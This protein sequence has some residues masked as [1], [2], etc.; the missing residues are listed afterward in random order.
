MHTHTHGSCSNVMEVRTLSWT[1]DKLIRR[2]SVHPSRSP[3]P[4]VMAM[5]I[6][7]DSLLARPKLDYD[8]GYDATVKGA[9]VVVLLHHM[10]KLSIYSN[11]PSFPVVKIN[12]MIPRILLGKLLQ[13]YIIC[14]FADPFYL[15]ILSSH[16]KY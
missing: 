14:V 10:Y 3:I 12:I 9:S 1:D 6:T 2:C 8:V 5:S 15:Y 11:Y 4:M 16:I 13:W 7:A